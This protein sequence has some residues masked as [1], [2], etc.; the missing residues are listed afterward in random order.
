MLID[1]ISNRKSGITLYGITPPRL[2]TSAEKL[3]EISNAQIQRIKSLKI[4]GL[5]IY[6]LQDEL[7]R[8]TENRPFPFMET[9][10]PFLYSENYLKSLAIPKVI[11]RAVG[12]YNAETLTEFMENALPEQYL[13]VFVG[14][15]SKQQ[16]VNLTIREA[17]NLKNKL[18]NNFL[19]GGVVIPERHATGSA[20]HLRVFDKIA[21]GCKFFISQG[22]YNLDASKSFLSDYYYYG[23]EQGIPLVP[24]IF[25]LTPCGSIKTLQF[26]KWLGI[27]I[28]KWLENELVNS[29]DILSKSIELSKNI[30]L[31]LKS[32]ADAKGIPVG[33]NIESVSIRK[34]EIDASIELLRL[35][36]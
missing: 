24:V 6:D 2:S 7:S 18:N 12:K 5:I 27:S 19:L 25:T 16:K 1:K 9:L 30:W 21:S 33:R 26:M 28:P 10:D 8:T 22:V 15:A 35:T 29:N 34:E 17:Y 13:S 3:A 32:F 31:E 11:Y 36:E 20:E 23:K 4:D 14:A